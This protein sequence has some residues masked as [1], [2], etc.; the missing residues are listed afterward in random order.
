MVRLMK[1]VM[2]LVAL[3]SLTSIGWAGTNGEATV[4]RMDHAGRVLHEIMS[5]PDK[6]IRKR[7]W[8]TR[9]ALL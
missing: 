4:N 6:G 1:K 2:V 9:N 7:F 8:S 5:A 3:L